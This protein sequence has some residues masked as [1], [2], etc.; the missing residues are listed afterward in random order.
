MKS[1]SKV[2]RSTAVGEPAA[3]RAF[4]HPTHVSL[5]AELLA[6]LTSAVLAASAI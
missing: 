4:A 1:L 5:V 3:F 2:Y 6:L